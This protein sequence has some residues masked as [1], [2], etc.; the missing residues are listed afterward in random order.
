[1]R[2][3]S[4][5]ITNAQRRAFKAI[6]SPQIVHHGIN[7][8][9]KVTKNTNKNPHF[10][11]PKLAT[12]PAMLVQELPWVNTTQQFVFNFSISGP[13]QI[14]GTNNNIVIAKNDVFCVYGV[15]M[16]FATGTNSADFIYRS[17]GVLPTDDA[18]YNSTIS[19]QI[20]SSKYVVNMEGQF[21]RDN[22]ANSNEYF[23]EIGLQLINPLRLISGENGVYNVTLNLKNPTS[24]LVISANTMLSMRLHGVYGQAQG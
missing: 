11:P 6:T 10:V 23:G 21:F 5:A 2:F 7:E 15:Q 19:M 3:D 24:P 14:P 1:M 16:L 13:A 8:Q 22:P 12:S 4:V 9:G 20:E 18:A 17:H